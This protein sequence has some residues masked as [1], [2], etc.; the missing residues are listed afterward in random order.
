M[1][2]HY[3]KVHE[4]RSEASWKVGNH[5]NS[6]F[7]IMLLW[8]FS[9]LGQE[10]SDDNPTKNINFIVELGCPATVLLIITSPRLGRLSTRLSFMTATW[11]HQCFPYF[12]LSIWHSQV[13]VWFFLYSFCFGLLSLNLKVGVFHWYWNILSHC[14]FRYWFCPVLILSGSPII[15]SD[16]LLM[17][18]TICSLFFF[19]SFFY[20]SFN[21]SVFHWLLPSSY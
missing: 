8:S 19:L 10:Q 6:I 13:Q 5:H 9:V 14:L 11:F 2:L 21:M 12:V 1:E 4:I 17:F 3:F 20:L 16:D 15:W 18:F 7:K